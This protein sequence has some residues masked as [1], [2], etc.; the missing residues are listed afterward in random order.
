M[1][2]SVVEITDIDNI[3]KLLGPVV[4]IWSEFGL[5]MGIDNDTLDSYGQ[6]LQLNRCLRDTI[7]LWIDLRDGEAT[8]GELLSAI[9]GTLVGNKALADRLRRDGE[10]VRK[11]AESKTC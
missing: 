7:Q 8:F 9:S 4:P 2:H 10:L 5:Q 1:Y 11:L 6:P 3:I